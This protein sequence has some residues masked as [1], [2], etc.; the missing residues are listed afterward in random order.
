M[1]HNWKHAYKTLDEILLGSKRKCENCGK[2]Q[3]REVVDYNV[4]DGSTY[5]W[6]PLVGRCKGENNDKS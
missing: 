2:I 5:R 4:M 6:L 1:R 3:F